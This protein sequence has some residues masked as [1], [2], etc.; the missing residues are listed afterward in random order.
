MVSNRNLQTSRGP[1]SGT[2][3]VLGSVLWK[4]WHKTEYQTL[5]PCLLVSAKDLRW[6]N[7]TLH[8][9][10]GCDFDDFRTLSGVFRV[11]WNSI[12]ISTSNS[13]TIG[14]HY[15]KLDYM[16]FKLYYSLLLWT[17]NHG[18]SGMTS[19]EYFTWRTI[20]IIKNPHRKGPSHSF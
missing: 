20:R 8:G 4:K 10:Y 15:G 18:F 6:Q 9:C 2:M 12:L 13:R 7:R 19:S 14:N 3:L 11:N 5:L 16:L 1:Y 17:S